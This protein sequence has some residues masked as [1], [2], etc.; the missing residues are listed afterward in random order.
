MWHAARTQGARERIYIDWNFTEFDRHIPCR[1]CDNG[2]G[3]V[4]RHRYF[5]CKAVGRER[6]SNAPGVD[7]HLITESTDE[8]DMR[9][10]TR[11]EPVR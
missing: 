7:N 11:Q 4:V 5:T 6:H 9:V 10:A 1:R 8:R 2:V 3:G